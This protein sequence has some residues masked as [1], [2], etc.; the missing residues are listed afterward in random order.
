MR[1]LLLVAV[2]MVAGMVFAACQSA[3]PPTI[4][5]IEVT[6]EVTVMVTADSAVAQMTP[7]VTTSPQASATDG[8]IQPTHT[9]APGIS[10]TPNVFPTTT[11]GQVYLA[12]QAFENGRLFWLEPVDQIWMITVD[13]E[14]GEERWSVFEDTF[15][16]GMAEFDAAIVPPVDLYQPERGF[17]KLWRENPDVRATL[18]WATE[19]EFG[20]ITRYEYHPGGIVN[21]ANVYLPAPGYH[22]LETINRE[23]IRFNEGKWN[24]EVKKLE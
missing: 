12:E 7:D 9:P 22:T 8:T 2:L 23:Q 11:V 6:R 17:G 14:T 20:Y 18:G 1:Y 4:Y 15:E 19:P 3:P 5:A 13:E 10:P 21:D 24:W 16:E